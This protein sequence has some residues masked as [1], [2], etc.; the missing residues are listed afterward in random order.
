[1][2]LTGHTKE[3]FGLDWNQTQRGYLASG[4]DDHL[5]C[6]WNT[7]TTEIYNNMLLPIAKYE[8][9]TDVVEDVS[10][11]SA[12]IYQLASVG[13]DRQIILWDIR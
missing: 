10:W 9:H 11:N 4:S 3:G 5:V 7:E 6:I 8:E 13:D 12:A 2:R 1:M